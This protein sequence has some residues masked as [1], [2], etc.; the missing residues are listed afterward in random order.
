MGG[1]SCE[2]SP[3]FDS[4]KFARDLERLYEGLIADRRRL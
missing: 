2:Q 4:E 1:L 3:L